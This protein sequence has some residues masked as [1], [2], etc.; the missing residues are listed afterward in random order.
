MK[1]LLSVVGLKFN[2]VILCVQLSVNRQ[3]LLADKKR[4]GKCFCVFFFGNAC[5]K[6]ICQ[7]L[8]RNVADKTLFEYLD[9]VVVECFSP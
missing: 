9:R 8:D 2:Q 1:S 7:R 3:G 6:R 4:E 5:T